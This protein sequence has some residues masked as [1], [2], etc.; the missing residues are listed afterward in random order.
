MKLPYFSQTY[1][2]ICYDAPEVFYASAWLSHL[3]FCPFGKFIL[4]LEAHNTFHKMSLILY[5]TYY[6]FYNSSQLINEC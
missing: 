3:I 5:L 6:I 4:R 2:E 1:P